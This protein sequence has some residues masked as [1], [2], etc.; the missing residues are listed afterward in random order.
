MNACHKKAGQTVYVLVIHV[1]TCYSCPFQTPPAVP[2]RP[3][4]SA[5]CDG[6]YWSAILVTTVTIER[7]GGSV[8]ALQTRSRGV[9]SAPPVC[10]P[11]LWFEYDTNHF[12]FNVIALWGKIPSPQNS[13]LIIEV[14]F[15]H[16]SFSFLILYIV[17][18]LRFSTLHIPALR[19][20]GISVLTSFFC[21]QTR[22]APVHDGV[23]ASSWR[24]DL[25]LS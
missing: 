3:H 10:L 2:I 11:S 24:R 15:W 7:N 25:R 9:L 22:Q 16:Y 12:P 6:H 23:I 5:C 13:D 14:V 1:R 19:D 20:A 18:L 21:Y 8:I 4:P 17:Y